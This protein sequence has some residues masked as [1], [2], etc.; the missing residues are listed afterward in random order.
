MTA[1]TQVLKF[2][3]FEFIHQLSI[4]N[5][6]ELNPLESMTISHLSADD[7]IKIA[8]EQEFPKKLQVLQEILGKHNLQLNMEGGL[9][10]G[11]M[12][13]DDYSWVLSAPESQKLTITAKPLALKLNM[14]EL[15]LFLKK[16]PLGQG[17]MF[18]ENQDLMLSGFSEQNVKDYFDSSLNNK[19]SKVLEATQDALFRTASDVLKNENLSL[20]IYALNATQLN[21][22]VN[23]KFGFIVFRAQSPDLQKKPR[24]IVALEKTS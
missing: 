17:F 23:P 24:I 16:L 19:D 18:H 13:L 15:V 5:S 21:R 9:V 10:I 22:E 7:F 12:N 11:A 2:S 6:V 3:I 20:K 1:T 8:N 4:G 14:H